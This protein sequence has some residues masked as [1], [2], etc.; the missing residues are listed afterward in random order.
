MSE[1]EKNAAL[2]EIEVAR[3]QPP[4]LTDVAEMLAAKLEPLLEISDYTVPSVSITAGVKAAS[5]YLTSTQEWWRGV[6]EFEYGDYERTP[7]AITVFARTLPQL[8][9]KMEQEIAQ[10]I[11]DMA[12]TPAT[13]EQQ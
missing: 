4:T 3:N 13:H 2:A 5:H 12:K 1:Q 11:N 6:V 9:A 10:F 8:I 7:V